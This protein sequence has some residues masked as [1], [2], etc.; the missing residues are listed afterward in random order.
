MYR[1]KLQHLQSKKPNNF[2]FLR[3]I[4]FPISVILKKNTNNAYFYD[5]IY[6]NLDRY[7]TLWKQ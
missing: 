4:N 7:N 2:L 3:T 5:S 6:S 1:E